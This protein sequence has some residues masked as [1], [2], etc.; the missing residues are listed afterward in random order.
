[1][2]Y[3]EPHLIGASLPDLPSD[4]GTVQQAPPQ[5]PT[6]SSSTPLVVTT[7]ASDPKDSAKHERGIQCVLIAPT[8]KRSMSTGAILV[9]PGKVS[10]S[11]N[12][13]WDERKS[14]NL[15]GNLFV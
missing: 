8:D 10:M 4:H 14:A 5:V 13:I 12:I 1:M 9:G 6:T 2:S 11:K 15:V 7:A 3:G